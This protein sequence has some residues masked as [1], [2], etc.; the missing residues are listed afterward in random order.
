MRRVPLATSTAL[1]GAAAAGSRILGFARDVLLA[2]I[3][4]AG[5]AADALVVALRLP[6][7]LRRVLGEGGLNA[8]IVPLARRIETGEG[9]HSAYVFAG[10]VLVT[11]ALILAAV[12]VVAEIAAPTIVLALAPGFSD[13]VQRLALATLCLRLT[14]PL[15]WGATMAALAAGLLNA[16]G[17]YAAAALAPLVVNAVLV[18]ILLA[19]AGKGWTPERLAPVLAA[20]VAL[21]GMLQATALLPALARLPVRPALV[22][23]RLSPE[24]RRAFALGLPGLAGLAAAQ[25]GIVVATQVASRSPE[26]VA[27]LYYAER[28][29][30]LPLGFVAAAAGIVLLPEIARLLAA[31]E[32]AAIHALQNRALE[33]A[34]A[35]SVPAAAALS[36]LAGPIV[37]ILFER[38]EFGAA[39]A[40]P[41]AAALAA[42]AWGLPAAAAARVLSQP[43][44]AR[45][46]PRPPLLCALLALVATG[47]AAWLLEPA[48]GAAGVAAGVSIGAWAGAGALGAALVPT[49]WWRWDADLARRLLLAALATILMALMLKA[50]MAGLSGWLQ[51]EAGLARRI[52]ALALL[53]GTG[54]ALYAALATLTG[55]VRWRDLAPWR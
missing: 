31:G 21:A 47:L 10:D 36:I 18:A 51:A 23:P 27:H 8:G 24:V 53:C 6:N 44:L 2:S 55:I 52:I 5:P 38:G 19:F 33:L 3:L 43:F 49:G 4:G 12:I 9:A 34:L 13:D 39:D 48:F 28:L 40:G 11:A 29:Y 25:F 15:A 45:E 26:A 7:L 30:Q 46:R 22:R 50:G 17:R 41:T 1:V 35:V 32:G 42:L 54:L 37:S 14:L 20:A 16:N